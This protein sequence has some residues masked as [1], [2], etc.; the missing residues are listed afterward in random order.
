MF[1]PSTL[2]NSFANGPTLV[3]AV[4]ISFA[5]PEYSDRPEGEL[6]LVPQNATIKLRSWTCGCAREFKFADAR[7]DEKR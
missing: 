5:L 7:I 3:D 2:P 6:E 1:D 4:H